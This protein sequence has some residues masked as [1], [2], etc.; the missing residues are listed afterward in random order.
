MAWQINP[1]GTR[2][3]LESESPLQAFDRDPRAARMLF[4]FQ[5]AMRL[6]PMLQKAA[7]QH[8][9]ARPGSVDAGDQVVQPFVDLQARA[10]KAG[11]NPLR[12][13]GVDQAL[14]S[15]A[16]LTGADPLNAEKWMMKGGTLTARSMPTSRDTAAPGPR[17]AFQRSA[18][19]ALSP[20]A[21]NYGVFSAVMQQLGLPGS[22]LIPG[23][24]PVTVQDAVAAAERMGQGGAEIPDIPI[25]EIQALRQRR[26]RKADEARVRAEQEARIASAQAKA[27]QDSLNHQRRLEVELVKKPAAD[28]A[29]IE[30]WRQD[31][32]RA[33][34]D[35]A[36]YDRLK[37]A[38]S[39]GEGLGDKYRP[40]Y[41]PPEAVR[42][43]LQALHQAYGGRP[44]PPATYEEWKTRAAR[45]GDP[46]F[47][48]SRPPGGGGVWGWIQE[49]LGIGQS[50]GGQG[51]QQG[52]STPA[53]L[54][55]ADQKTI[56]KL[57]SL[58]LSQQK[59]F[60]ALMLQRNPDQARRLAPLLGLKVGNNG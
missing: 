48:A 28:G 56:G 9:Y 51:R 37:I 23:K 22:G 25:P 31:M 13:S 42:S 53:Q 4:E 14:A 49:A 57:R 59:E 60:L 10:Q 35:Q 3:H 5:R 54:D 21:G 32:S 43:R 11:F 58:P 8:L 26:A 16:L 33:M 6:A 44:S 2:E 20:G 7:L 41:V 40:D 50:G 45:R 36:S 24:G 12:D 18:T 34:D 15:Q 29:A 52:M 47:P 1:D 46:R 27:D 55:A 19:G 30:D 39:K 17:P 38:A